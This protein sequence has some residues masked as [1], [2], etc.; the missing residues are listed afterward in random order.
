[1]HFAVVSTD[2]DRRHGRRIT[3]VIVLTG[4]NRLQDCWQDGDWRLGATSL[5]L[6]ADWGYCRFKVGRFPEA[7][8]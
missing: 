3:Q 5:G 4:G 2:W 7:G 1:M 8:G 6:G